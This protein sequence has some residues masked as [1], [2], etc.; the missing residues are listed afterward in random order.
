MPGR[1]GAAPQQRPGTPTVQARTSLREVADEPGQ[2]TS[3]A[4][5]HPP[6]EH[7][8]QYGHDAGDGAEEAEADEAGGGDGNG[9]PHGD[10][11]SDDA[12]RNYTKSTKQKGA[13]LEV[14]Y[15]FR[16]A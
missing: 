11:D 7:S 12:T 2:R 15:T 9:Y 16:N 5:I 6:W 4:P 10:R 1:T 3:Q 14:V 8:P 13:K